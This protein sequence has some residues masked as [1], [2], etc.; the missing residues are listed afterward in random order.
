MSRTSHMSL[1]NELTA[2]PQSWNVLTN[3]E[4]K[5]VKNAMN[6]KE[7]TEE[8]N[9]KNCSTDISMQPETSINVHTQTKHKHMQQDTLE[10]NVS[11]TAIKIRFPFKWKYGRIKKLTETEKAEINQIRHRNRRRYQKPC[12]L[13]GE[14][15]VIA[16]RKVSD[17]SSTL[18]CKECAERYVL[19]ARSIEKRIA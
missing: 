8:T 14:E 7:P 10:H 3:A 9:E 1:Y 6:Q 5:A 13:C 16:F 11:A 12:C 17:G 4:M 15:G 19:S 18:I 2:S